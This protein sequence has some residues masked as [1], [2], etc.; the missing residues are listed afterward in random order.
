M[1]KGAITVAVIALLIGAGGLGIGIMGMMQVP[2]S[3]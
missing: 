2:L 3:I 1:S